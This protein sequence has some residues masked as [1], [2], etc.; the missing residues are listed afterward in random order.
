MR[1]VLLFAVLLTLSSII[2]GQNKIILYNAN[3][4]DG[5]ASVEGDPPMLEPHVNIPW[6][7]SEYSVGR[8]F[9]R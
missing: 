7:W 4:I 6:V 2:F 3:L 9:S 1:K 5:I 8:V